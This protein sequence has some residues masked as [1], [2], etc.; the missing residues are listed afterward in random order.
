MQDPHIF[1]CA[2]KWCFNSTDSLG[3][4]DSKVYFYNICCNC[5][6]RKTPIVLAGYFF[7]EICYKQFADQ[8]HAAHIANFDFSFHW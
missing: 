8:F 4:A 2:Y 5:T 3:A 6:V 1:T 7:Y